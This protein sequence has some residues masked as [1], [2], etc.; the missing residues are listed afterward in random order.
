VIAVSPRLHGIFIG[1][2][3]SIVGGLRVRL[4]AGIYWR[5]IAIA[6][7]VI[8]ALAT[9]G[10]VAALPPLLTI[11]AKPIRSVIVGFFVPL[12]TASWSR[13]TRVG[14]PPASGLFNFVRI[15]ASS[16]GAS[17]LTAFPNQ[18][19]GRFQ[20][21][22][23]TSSKIY[24]LRQDATIR[25]P[26]RFGIAVLATCFIALFTL[27]GCAPVLLRAPL[28]PHS[29]V[30][31][32][33]PTDIRMMGADRRF[34]YESIQ[35]VAR[36]AHDLQKG[37][38]FSVLALSGGGA[39]GAF[40]AGALVGLSRSGARQKF[41]VVT[42]VSA[43]A[44]L[45]PYAFLGP[46]WDQQLM[47]A[48]TSGR[49]EHLLQ[50]R[51]LGVIFGSS[52]YRGRP[53]ERLVDTF[54]S[55]ALMQAVAREAAAGRLLL[56]AT[57]NV[58]TGE[59]VVWDLGSVA[60][61]GGAIAKALFRD[62]L[63]ASAS[64]PGMFPPVIIR[65]QDSWGDYSEAHV[66]GTATVPFFVPPA[67]LQLPRDV[68]RQSPPAVYVIIDGRLSEE[69]ASTRL[70]FRTSRSRSI[71]AGL[72]HMA[73]TT[74]EL[75]ATTAELQG[76][77]LQYSAI[78]AAYRNLVPFDFSTAAMRSLFQFGYECALTSRL[79][80][81]SQSTVTDRLNRDNSTPG[82]TNGCPADDEFIAGFAARID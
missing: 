64:V 10:I 44:L 51:H 52:A 77:N 43:G 42:G 2:L 11:V 22:S 62:I 27:Q 45:A 58:D 25:A 66:G 53:L 1:D 4:G 14:I 47:D 48:Y 5:G 33:T 40:G 46:E 79:W 29:N 78:P 8:S 70:W 60:M 57:T 23:V 21:Y 9:L 36:R 13:L 18:R 3:S 37:E 71:S 59:T 34:A 49:A 75:T 15:A 35:R 30:A 6:I 31:A 74:L 12:I 56:V 69:Q 65:V 82:Q 72:T 76:A 20:N 81:S 68:A 80:V 16:F 41:A 73:R 17:F 54:L 26:L 55:D 50:S 61:Y 19:A 67:L 24:G 63:V 38:P 7:E 32:N 28:P 39:D